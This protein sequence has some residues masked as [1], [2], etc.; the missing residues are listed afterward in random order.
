VK[1]RVSLFLALF[2]VY[3]T[4]LAAP[5][6]C[7][8]HVS[9]GAVAAQSHSCCQDQTTARTSAR[10]A[11]CCDEREQQQV[12]VVVPDSQTSSTLAFTAIVDTLEPDPVPSL[13]VQ[14]LP[15]VEEAP[16][17]QLLPGSVPD[18]RAPPA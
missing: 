10:S 1:R 13:T 16:P 15:F 17:T 7:A 2:V 11:C 9:R 18:L 8:T 5:C 12:N 14:T 3:T 4:G 6:Y